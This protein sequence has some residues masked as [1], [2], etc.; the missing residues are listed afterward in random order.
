MINND[1]IPKFFIACIFNPSK[2]ESSRFSFTEKHFFLINSTC[3]QIYILFSFLI[4]DKIGKWT[5]ASI[6]R[7]CLSNSTEISASTKI[8]IPNPSFLLG[9]ARKPM[10]RFA[11]KVSC[12]K[13]SPYVTYIPNFN[14]LNL[15]A[16]IVI[17]RKCFETNGNPKR[18]TD[19]Y[20]TSR[21]LVSAYI[22]S[23]CIKFQDFRPHRF[24]DIVITRMCFESK[25][26]CIHFRKKFFWPI[27][28]FSS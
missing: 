24:D 14:H 28:L 12:V 20:L 26:S 4:W 9:G 13:F 27:S 19:H 2:I 1:A 8:T 15:S 16:D 6:T 18:L 23:L 21:V 22:E 25:V 5:V 7:L 17:K 3:I 10:N 11:L